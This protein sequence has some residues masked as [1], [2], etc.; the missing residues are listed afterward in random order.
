M[1]HFHSRWPGADHDSDLLGALNITDS[2]CQSIWSMSALALRWTLRC[3]A[4][5]RHSVLPEDRR[6]RLSRMPHFLRVA[7]LTVVSLEKRISR[8]PEALQTHAY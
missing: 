8:G 5:V 7:R 2:D 4:M 3:C 6:Q 1:G